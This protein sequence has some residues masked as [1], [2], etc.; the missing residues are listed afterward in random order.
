MAPSSR[1]LIVGILLTLAPQAGAD[2][3]MTSI[4]ELAPLFPGSESAPLTIDLSDDCQDLFVRSG[5]NMQVP[6]RV[7]PATSSPHILVLGPSE[8]LFPLESCL[9]GAQE[10][11]ATLHWTVALERDAPGLELLRADIV[12]TLAATPGVPERTSEGILH[13]TGKPLVT[14][15][16][17]PHEKLVLVRG[18]QGA[19]NVTVVNRGNVKTAVA[20][21]LTE[22]PGEG[23][24]SFPT[25]IVL[26]TNLS[27]LGA[28]TSFPVTFQA[29][30]GTWS[31]AV[32]QVTLTP[33][34][35]LD[36][37][38]SGAPVTMNLLF[39]NAN[40]LEREAPSP[41]APLALA[42]LMAIALLRRRA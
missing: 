10:S 19:I 26:N 18:D 5:G 40:A 15:E 28:S 32:A 9:L 35:F 4:W 39:R 41:T 8:A 12:A 20:L 23:T 37:A 2:F 29:P 17:Q 33:S 11:T 31:Q 38:A 42:G 22:L 21:T 24:V 27:G 6:A 3:T 34:A 14:L 7:V 16:V 36:P 1:L 13:V 25:T 30:R